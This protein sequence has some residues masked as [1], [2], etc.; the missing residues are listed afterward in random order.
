MSL[1][2]EQENTLTPILRLAA[3]KVSRNFGTEYL[4]TLHECWE[5]ALKDDKDKQP[6][7]LKLLAWVGNGRHKQA[8]LAVVEGVGRNGYG[9]REK[10]ARLGVK[11]SKLDRRHLSADQFVYSV[12]LVEDWLPMA[13]N[14]GWVPEDDSVD[15]N[16]SG[17]RGRKAPGEWGNALAIV[18]DLRR[19]L[20]AGHQGAEDIANWLNGGSN[21]TA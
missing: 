8:M 9:V 4:D 20:S 18:M 10:A 21:A 3:N 15:E 11:P 7:Y 17:K 16:E 1:T 12:G 6:R 14:P 13:R 5:W 19:A 2:G